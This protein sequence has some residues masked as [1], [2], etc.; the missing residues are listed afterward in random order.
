MSHWISQ[1]NNNNLSL[2]TVL[3][4]FHRLTKAHTGKNVAEAILSLINC[5]NVTSKVCSHLLKP[6]ALL[7]AIDWPFHP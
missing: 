2:K 1:D 3:I 6:R 7:K 4:G 5:A